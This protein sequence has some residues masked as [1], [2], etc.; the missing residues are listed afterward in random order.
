MKTIK[1]MLFCLPLLLVAC[2]GRTT[3]NSNVNETT[4][5][6]TIGNNHATQMPKSLDELKANFMGAFSGT[7]PCADCEGM[8]TT[9]TL[10]ADGT[11]ILETVYQG[12]GDDNK[13]TEQG[14]WT[15]SDD[16]TFIELNYD[17]RND[18]GAVYYAL[19][20]RNTLEKLDINAEP[21]ISELNYKLIRK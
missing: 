1:V 17:R 13:F 18:S 11:Y 16:L 9:L 3:D 7:L 2:K 19:I 21:I 15:P 4:E 14:K 8:L 10:N 5:T 20:D 12:K 6:E